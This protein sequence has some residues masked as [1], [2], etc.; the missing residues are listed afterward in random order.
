MNSKRGKI[1]KLLRT[2]M[3]AQ[4]VFF[5]LGVPFTIWADTTYRTDATQQSKV[6]KGTVVDSNGEPIIGANVLVKGENGIGVVTDLNGGFA[7]KL[8]FGIKKI[9]VTFIGYVTQE[10]AVK[11]GQTLRIVLAENAEM[12]DEVQIIAYGTQS[13]VS[14]TGS[15][16][17]IRTDELLKVPNASITNALAGAMTGVTAVQSI[18]QPGME[19]AKLYIRGSSTLSNDGS[20]APLVLVDGIERPFSQIDANEVADITVLKDASATAVFGV[21]GANGV[22]LVTT[23]RGNQG[24]ATVTVSSNVSVQMPT[25]LIESCDSYHTALYYNEKI[26]NDQSSKPRFDEYAL[27]AFKTG[28]DPIIYPN[29][30]WRKLVFKDAYLQTQN[31]INLSGGTERVRYFTSLGYLYQDGIIKQ[32][33]QLDY[34]NKF[35]Y[36]RFNYRANLDIDVTKSTLL[37]INIG[38]VVGITHEPRGHSDG[39]WR[40]V[41]WASPFASPG[42]SA[43]GYPVEIGSQYLPIPTKTGLAAFY[44]LGFREKTKNDL[45]IDINVEQKL[46]FVTKGLK[47]HLKGSYNTYYT[48]NVERSSNVQKYV[49]YYEG[50]KTQPGVKMDDPTFNKNLVYE[51]AGNNVPMQY[52]EGYSRARNWYLEGGL[53]YSNTFKQVHRVSV[54][55]LYNQNRVYYPTKPDGGEMD[56]QYIPRSYVGLVGR[57]SYGY[58]S[59]YLFDINIG[60]NGSENFAPGKTRFGVFPSASVGWVISEENFM[61]GQS[62]VSFLKLRASYGVVGNDKIGGDRFLYMDGIWSVNGG[63]Y[64]F[65]TNVTTKEPA[66]TEGKLG[67][68]QVTWEKATKQNYGIDFKILND[69]LSFTADYF[70]ELRSDILIDRNTTPDILAMTLPK[71]NMGEVLNQGY[72]L[73]LKWADKIQDVQYWIGTNMSYAK[74]KILYMDEAKHVNSFNNQTGRSTGLTYGY[75]FE[76]FYTKDDFLNPEKGILKEELSKP[77]FGTPFP[78][79]CKYV[80]KDGNGTIGPDDQAWLGYSTQRPDYVFGLSYGA[81]W[82][83]WEF[84]MQWVGA[85]NVSR[86]LATEYRIPFSPSGNRALF[87]YHVDERW[88]PETAATA[89][90]PRFSD[91]SKALNYDV[92]SSLWVKDASYI[93][94]KNVQIGYKFYKKEW[95]RMLGMNSL[96]LYISGYNLLTFDRLKFIDPEAP[97]NGGNSNQYP[98]SKM[99]TMGVKLNF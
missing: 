37:K 11:D 61:K 75:E 81:N 72:E 69:R 38:G 5:L 99:V 89:T 85:T 79:D 49:A 14:V 32:F 95:L 10:V 83:G 48:M 6:V 93:R 34:N 58:N 36:N 42:L 26:D 24:K 96:D 66:A 29:T 4:L 57:A 88:T 15:M 25:R 8:P 33:D 9:T 20:D 54:L 3:C 39:L 94:L 50:T 82:K 90:M 30:D 35:S 17:S 16:S 87:Q 70:R 63:G 67:N 55:L 68:P 73:E 84:T 44:G 76:R 1:G 31:N 65:G 78:G 46:D 97:T 92:N 21:R 47:F 28:S 86:N 77:S 53:N 64:N 13:K 56:Y 7:L 18:G 12:L 74:N 62:F 2:Y 43:D 45:N 22:I 71:V 52:G 80:D 51:I 41:N 59:R 23:R 19:E 91:S 60:Y 40:Q 98:V 27:N